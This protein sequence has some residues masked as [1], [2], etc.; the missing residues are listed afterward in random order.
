MQT[1][2]EADSEDYH[3]QLAAS[4]EALE[5]ERKRVQTLQIDLLTRSNESASLQGEADR[6]LTEAKEGLKVKDAEITKLKKQVS[7]F[8]FLSLFFFY[9]K[10]I[11]L[12]RF[13]FAV[14]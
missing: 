1:Q 4:E 9:K 11:L 8:F 5:K 7:L 3:T 2:A 12:Y 10:F 6:A 14:W 13:Y